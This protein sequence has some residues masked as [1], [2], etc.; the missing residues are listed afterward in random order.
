MNKLLK[1][2]QKMQ[3]Q[4]MKAQEELVKKEVEGTAGG[5]M[6][7]VMLSGDGSL[8]SIKLDKQVVDPNDVEMLE[9]LI[10][11]A[12][13]NAQEKIK[14]LSSSTFGNITGGMKLPGM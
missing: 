8:Q 6:V 3:A 4:M 12:F 1:Q 5:G 9:D 14:E 11:A 10:L 2:A 13:N 7:K